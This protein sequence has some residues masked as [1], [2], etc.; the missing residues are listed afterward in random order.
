MCNHASNT[1]AIWTHVSAK[2][3]NT[4]NRDNGAT[5]NTTNILSTKQSK[6]RQEKKKGAVMLDANRKYYHT[7]NKLCTC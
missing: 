5:G 4:P 7:V 6:T 1:E 3:K 2:M